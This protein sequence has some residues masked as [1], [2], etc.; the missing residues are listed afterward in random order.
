[1]GADGGTGAIAQLGERQTEEIHFFALPDPAHAPRSRQT[2]SQ[3][4]WR[5]SKL[6]RSFWCVEL[7]E[8]G[9]LVV[10]DLYGNPV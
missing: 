5:S 6:S 4:I 7:Q 2:L 9:E 10:V 8:A 3:A 1:M